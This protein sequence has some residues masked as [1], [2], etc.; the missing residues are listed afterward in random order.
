MP[1]WLIHPLAETVAVGAACLAA[2]TL[3]TR[4]RNRLIAL[5]LLLTIY[6]IGNPAR[7]VRQDEFLWAALVS[8][9]GYCGLFALVGWLLHGARDRLGPAA[10]FAL[11]P[12]FIYP[13]ALFAAALVAFRLKS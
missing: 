11:L 12:L 3:I 6:A 1:A 7:L 2:W 9:A 13:F 8:I 10:P 5:A 4:D